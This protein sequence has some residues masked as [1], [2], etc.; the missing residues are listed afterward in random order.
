MSL[1]SLEFESGTRYKRSLKHYVPFA[2]CFPEKEKIP[3]VN[4]EQEDYLSCTP[5]QSLPDAE[6]DFF[7]PRFSHNFS[8]VRVHADGRAA[9]A[10]QQIK[11]QAF[12]DES[13]S[14][15]RSVTRIIDALNGITTPGNSG[16]QRT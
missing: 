2:H 4:S 6:R 13:G 9:K 7:E 5:G 11:A 14:E 8:R 3:K 10:A 16:Y 12:G 1:K 15:D